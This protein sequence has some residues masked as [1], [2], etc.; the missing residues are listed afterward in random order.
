MSNKLD[1]GEIVCGFLVGKDYEGQ[2]DF[3]QTYKEVTIKKRVKRVGDGDEDF[4]IEEYEDVKEIPIKEVIE[5]Q[6]DQV[7][8]EAYMRPYQMAGVDLPGVEVSDK[9]FDVSNFPEDPADAIKVGDAMMKA[10]QSLDPMLKG[11]AKTPEE[12]LNT[13][14]DERLK[15]YFEAKLNVGKDE[16]DV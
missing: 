11:D 9:I 16:K 2:K 5:S 12:F 4:I 1:T 8:I 6:C 15:A 3:D 10:W 14:N 13:I 7:G